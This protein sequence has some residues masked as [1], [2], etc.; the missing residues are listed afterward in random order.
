[1]QARTSHN[2]IVWLRVTMLA[3]I[4][5]GAFALL[6]LGNSESVT[7][8]TDAQL[9]LNGGDQLI[10]KAKNCNLSVP[11]NISTQI[12]VACAAF[13]PTPTETATATATA[14]ETET[15]TPTSTQESGFAQLES[16]SSVAIL[17]STAAKLKRTL[18]GGQKL[19]VLASTASGVACKLELV[20]KSASKV[21]INC[22]TVATAVPTRTRTPIPSSAT[23][24][25]R[26]NTGGT[27]CYEIKNTGIGQKC[28]GGGDSLYGSFSPG[29]YAWTVSAVCGNASG[30]A[31]FP[32][33]TWLHSFTCANRL[34]ER[35]TQFPP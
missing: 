4:V 25:V 15:A 6:M 11:K 16:G 30:T 35:V 27:L 14:T 23:V 7:A 26:N 12:R 31:N 3:L 10:V 32:A 13:T 34:S 28:F 33:G 29:T 24:Y 5:V 20:S 1:M 19:K 18:S 8:D 9:T 21:K 2:K 22:K 17:N